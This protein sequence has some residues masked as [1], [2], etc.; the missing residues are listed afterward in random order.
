MVD[1]VSLLDSSGG[2]PRLGVVVVMPLP[3]PRLSVVVVEHDLVW[4]AEAADRVGQDG[5]TLR[6]TGLDRNA[7]HF[8]SKSVQRGPPNRY[9]RGTAPRVATMAGFGGG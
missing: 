4:S 1:P 8:V 6:P 7:G 5:E 2:G 3:P 9:P